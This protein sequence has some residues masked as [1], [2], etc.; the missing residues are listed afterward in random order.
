MKAMKDKRP[1]PDY[2]LKVVSKEL[3]QEGRGRL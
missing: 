3:K 2:L 1:D